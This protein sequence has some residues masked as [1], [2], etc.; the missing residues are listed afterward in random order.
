MD[1]CHNDQLFSGIK[2]A[3]RESFE[4]LWKAETSEKALTSIAS[5][6]P[7]EL[8]LNFHDGNFAL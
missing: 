3:L 2:A 5:E 6:P 8:L 4:L 7:N 1:L